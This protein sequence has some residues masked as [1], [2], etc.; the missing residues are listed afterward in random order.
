M[1]Q[2]ALPAPHAPVRRRVLFG[3]FDADGWAWASMKALFWFVV[4]ILMLGYIPDRAYYFTV[5]R[6]LDLGVLGWSPINLC[7]AENEG[8]E[9]PVPP[10]STLPWHPSPSEIRLPAGRTDGA[11]VAAGPKTLYVGGSDGT[12]AVST[13]F[14]TSGVG[15]GNLDGW[16]AGPALPEP[17][18]DASVV[19][20]GTSVYVVG[21]RDATGAPTSSV[22]RLAVSADGALGQWETVDALALP[23]PRAGAAIVALPDGLL[24]LGGDD[25]TGP[26][27]T[28]WK[29]PLGTSGAPGAWAPQAELYEPNADGIAMNV[30]DYVWLLGGRKAAGPVAT[31]QVGYLNPEGQGGLPAGALAGWRVSDQTNLPAPRTNGAGFTANGTLYLVGGSDGS[32]AQRDVWWAIP[33]TTGALSGWE[34]SAATDLGQGIEGATAWA[35]GSHAFTAGGRTAGGL[36]ADLARANLAP[37][38]PFF[39]LGVLGATVPAL[40]IEGEIGQQLGYLNAAGAGTLNF[41]VLLLIGYLFNH[42]AKARA[43]WGRIRRR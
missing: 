22:F 12:A 29:A 38:G 34:H 15:E 11:V 8:L 3:L 16:A 5:N 23:A 35:S 6:T 42:P 25:G 32:A 21:G 9:C 33:D 37:Q 19:A 41:V 13:V 26:T 17:R 7:P 1:A 24:L 43:L 2:T 14:V 20:L 27:S 4:I 39:Q 36:T 10:G 30:G 40:K 18:A 31:V 28:A